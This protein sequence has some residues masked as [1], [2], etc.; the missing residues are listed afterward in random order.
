MK[1]IVSILLLAFL[2]LS[3]FSQTK[4]GTL[5]IFSELTGVSVYLDEA[6][7]GEDIK[8]INSVPVGSHYLKVLLGTTSVYGDLV[9]I[10]D[11]ETTT[12]LI[13]NT[14]QV[15]EKIMDGKVTERE[16][17]QNSKIEVLLSSNA[18][19]S[20]TGKSTMYPGYYGY[21]G[22]NKSVS[23]TTNE[24]D[25]KIVQ[26]GVKEIGEMNLATLAGNQEILNRNAADNVRI[27][28]TTG[29]GAGIFLGSLAIGVPLLV[30]MLHKS[31]PEKPGGFLHKTTPVHAKWETGVLAGTIVTGIISYAIVM[32]ADKSKPKHYYTPDVAN[33]DAQ[34]YNKKLKEKLGLPESYDVK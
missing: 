4:T 28:K 19:T 15:Q 25:F 18:I 24:T 9:D 30:D 17:Y 16:E 20:T 34:G 12:I 3:S 26:G 5:K 22:Y 6:K 29:I 7:Q 21:Y 11:G 1:K 27:Q 13:K 2:T 31:T 14:G 8:V 33:R 23:V 32:G 10:K